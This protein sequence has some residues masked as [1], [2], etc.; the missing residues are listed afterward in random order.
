MAVEELLASRTDALPYAIVPL[1]DQFTKTA[2]TL[3]GQG[4]FQS[5]QVTDWTHY[6]SESF[7]NAVSQNFF[8]P[9]NN[10]YPFLERSVVIGAKSTTNEQILRSKGVK[11]LSLFDERNGAGFPCENNA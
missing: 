1:G 8:D 11:T 3:S 10:L 9:V 6:L 4:S 5:L 7:G 2:A